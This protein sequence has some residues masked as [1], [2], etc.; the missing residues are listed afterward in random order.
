MDLFAN[1]AAL[2]ALGQP[3]R[4]QY[5]LNSAP[6]PRSYNS[7]LVDITFRHRSLACDH[8]MYQPDVHGCVYSLRFRSV[9][10]EADTVIGGGDTQQAS[11]EA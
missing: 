1:A 7:E 2:I 8:L 10:G 5:F 9:Y 4:G 11:W 6:V 3:E